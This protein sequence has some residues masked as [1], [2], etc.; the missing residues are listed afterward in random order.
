MYHNRL[1]FYLQDW[2]RLLL[3]ETVHQRLLL[4]EIL[5]SQFTSNLIGWEVG[6]LYYQQETGITT[7]SK[8]TSLPETRL[9]IGSGS[10]EPAAPPVSHHLN[11]LYASKFIQSLPCQV[12]NPTNKLYHPISL[13]SISYLLDPTHYLDFLS[14]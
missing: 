7:V 9:V 10:L 1:P 12:I 6:F 13:L 4:Q 11:Q 2:R 14:I 5:Q 3:D 8:I